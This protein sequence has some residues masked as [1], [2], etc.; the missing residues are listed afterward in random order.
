MR[1]GVRL[2]FS[3]SDA[4]CIMSSSNRKHLLVA[5]AIVAFLLLGSLACAS[6]QEELKEYSALCGLYE[7][8]MASSLDPEKKEDMVIRRIYG[9]LP[10]F[11]EHFNHIVMVDRADMYRSIKQLA[12]SRTGKEWSCVAAELLY[13]S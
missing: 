10:I 5:V 7:D 13:K 8:A 12:E 6:P 4:G 1:S 3:A 11:S 2:F 9:E